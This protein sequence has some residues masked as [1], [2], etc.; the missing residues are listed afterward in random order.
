MFSTNPHSPHSPHS[1]LHSAALIDK[2]QYAETQRASTAS[3]LTTPSSRSYSAPEPVSDGFLG[4][5]LFN[6]LFRRQSQDTGAARRRRLESGE[7]S[8]SRP[9]SRA[10]RR[11][12]L[13]LGQDMRLVSLL[14]REQVSATRSGRKRSYS[15]VSSLDTTQTRESSSY[16]DRPARSEKPAE[17]RELNTLQQAI[18][19][20]RA[21]A[22]FRSAISEDTQEGRERGR[23]RRKSHSLY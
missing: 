11:G 3:F 13:S 6:R 18:P 2:E 16:R 4:S 15:L 5:D 7:V 10:S 23:T 1:R 17:L 9:L 21:A 22:R 19:V 8:E 20:A 12:S 14:D